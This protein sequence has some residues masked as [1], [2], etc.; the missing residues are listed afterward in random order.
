MFYNVTII[1]KPYYIKN[2]V[3]SAEAIGTWGQLL[4]ESETDLVN[5]SAASVQMENSFFSDQWALVK[6]VTPDYSTKFS[7]SQDPAN[8][9]LFLLFF[10][11]KRLNFSDKFLGQVYFMQGV[12]F[13]FFLFGRESKHVRKE[14][15]ACWSGSLRLL[16][17]IVLPVSWTWCS[18]RVPVSGF[19]TDLCSSLLDLSGIKYF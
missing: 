1:S 10:G 4:T 3:Y 15:L 2:A 5:V 19:K 17:C 13:A 6:E 9:S 7:T 18:Y 14:E 16:Q 12:P 11:G 8:V